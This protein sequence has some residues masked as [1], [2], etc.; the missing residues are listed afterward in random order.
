MVFPHAS[1]LYRVRL[2]NQLGGDL[3]D[4]IAKKIKGLLLPFLYYST[5]VLS[6]QII[7]N[8]NSFPFFIRN[9]WVSYALWFI[10]VLLLASISARMIYSLKNPLVR[11]CL[12]GLFL[13]FGLI[14]CYYNVYLSW[15][16]SSVPYAT[17][18]IAMGKK[19]KGFQN[20]LKPNMWKICL[21]FV[22]T[23]TISRFWHLDMCFNNILPIIPITFGA[24]S[25]TLLIFMISMFVEKKSQF[26]TRMFTNIGRETLIIVA[27]SQ[28]TIVIFNTFICS[29]V[30]VK[31]IGLIVI[32]FV[33]TLLKNWFKKA[34]AKYSL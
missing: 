23:L 25:G 22:L 12:L 20:Q 30:L 29:N 11:L 1:V 21:L 32:L 33:A 34:I 3:S 26:L 16:L 14:L 17:F 9:G 28:I 6:I 5:I 24:I 4:Y 31:Y 10:P 15:T 2:Y 8:L 7:L 18:L 13:T 27:F 19:L